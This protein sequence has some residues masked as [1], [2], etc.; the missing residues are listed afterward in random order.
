MN[1]LKQKQPQNLWNTIQ[2][3]KPPIT[4]FAWGENHYITNIYYLNAW[5]FKQFFVSI[6]ILNINDV[7]GFKISYY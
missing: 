5:L 1:I 6:K 7:Y 4:G 2:K 3:L